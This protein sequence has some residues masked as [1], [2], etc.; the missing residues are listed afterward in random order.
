MLERVAMLSTFAPKR[1]S[2]VRSG[3]ITVRSIDVR[4]PGE[5][6]LP[7]IGRLHNRFRILGQDCAIAKI[8]CYVTRIFLGVDGIE[9]DRET[10]QG[11]HT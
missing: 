11:G 8:Y 6:C 9:D 3:V 4:I 10:R 7:G 5:R 1:G 2:V